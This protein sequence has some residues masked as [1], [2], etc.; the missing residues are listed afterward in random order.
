M[1]VLVLLL[2][3]GG[4]VLLES[5]RGDQ[6]DS[7]T[8]DRGISHLVEGLASGQRDDFVSAQ[9]EFLDVNS[10]WLVDEYAAFALQ[11]TER[12]RRRIVGSDSSQD[13]PRDQTA[14]YYAA[15]AR[16]DLERARQWATNHASE[17][18]SGAAGRSKYML[19]FITDIERVG[20]EGIVER[21]RGR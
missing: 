18:T 21:I 6:R 11:T 9:K 3:L 15:I 20:G 4:L 17:S 2:G 8:I 7:Q 19:R 12:L 5:T 10:G 1:G 16:G 13:T 14:P